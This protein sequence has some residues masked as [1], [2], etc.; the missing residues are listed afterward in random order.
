MY[1]TVDS[2]SFPFLWLPSP[3]HPAKYHDFVYAVDMQQI[4]RKG[5]ELM[6]SMGTGD[7][8]QGNGEANTAEYAEGN[9]AG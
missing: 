7:R 9:R 1:G 3:S 5:Q 8:L 2:M 6:S 4:P